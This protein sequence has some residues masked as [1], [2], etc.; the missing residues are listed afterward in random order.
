MSLRSHPTSMYSGPGQPFFVTVG[1]DIIRLICTLLFT[2]SRWILGD[3]MPTIPGPDDCRII[4]VRWSLPRNPRTV[5]SEWAT[6]YGE[7]FKLR[8]GFYDYV[9]INSPEAF[10]EIFVKQAWRP[11][12]MHHLQETMTEMLT[13]NMSSS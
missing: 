7:L 10:Q 5:M 4:Q 13:M 1:F 3:P 2:I 11:F 6:T 8:V 9:V 12:T